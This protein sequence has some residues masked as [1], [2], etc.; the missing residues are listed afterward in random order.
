M[1]IELYVKITDG[2][3]IYGEYLVGEPLVKYINDY[4]DNEAKHKNI[5]LDSVFVHYFIK[6]LKLCD[7]YR[8]C[9]INYWLSRLKIILQET[10]QYDLI[11]YR[12]NE[13]VYYMVRERCELDH[14]LSW[15]STLGGAFSALGK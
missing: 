12:W 15:L 4:S 8:K 14:A 7:F 10:H 9:F 2:N 11:D 1:D 3:Y 13:K 5:K 6:E